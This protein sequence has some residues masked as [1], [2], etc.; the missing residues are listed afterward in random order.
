ME[1][2]TRSLSFPL[3]F[4][5]RTF[6]Q[7][8]TQLSH[9]RSHCFLPTRARPHVNAGPA[10]PNLF[11][12][13]LLKANLKG[14]HI[15]TDTHARP[16]SN[17]PRIDFAN[18]TP[19]SPENLRGPFSGESRLCVSAAPEEIV[20]KVAA[21][22]SQLGREL[23]RNAAAVVVLRFVSGKMYGQ[24]RCI[25]QRIPKTYVRWVRQGIKRELIALQSSSDIIK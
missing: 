5:A 20:R 12:Y 1:L 4:S 14:E 15:Q 19:A 17:C 6:K 24:G 9:P 11:I 25:F 2:L 7:K 10:R 8:S 21:A 3:E 16:P 23:A 13:A 22:P 18:R